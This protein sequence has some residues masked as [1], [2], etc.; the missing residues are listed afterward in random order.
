[1][2][3]AG[4]C[5]HAL[6]ALYRVIAGEKE[7]TELFIS[8][9]GVTAVSKVKSKWPDDD[10]VQK[11]VRVLMGPVSKELNGWTKAK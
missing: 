10:E 11:A 4:L 1:M 3:C 7:S 2:G 5:G 6:T 8:V 9:G